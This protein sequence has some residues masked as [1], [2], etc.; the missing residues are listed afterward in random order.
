MC[1]VFTDAAFENDLTRRIFITS[2]LFTYGGSTI[3]YQSKTHTLTAG[4]STEAECIATVTAA[5]FTW[6]F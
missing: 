6:Y 5:K 3:I 2:V 4:S 1:Q